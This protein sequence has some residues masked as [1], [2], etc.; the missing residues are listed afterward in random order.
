MKTILEYLKRRNKQVYNAV[1]LDGGNITL[2]TG[3]TT[4]VMRAIPMT[5]TWYD[6][7]SYKDLRAATLEEYRLI[8]DYHNEINQVLKDNHLPELPYDEYW[9]CETKAKDTGVTATLFKHDTFIMSRGQ[10]RNLEFPTIL[11][12]I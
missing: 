8:H 5:G 9:T 1:T 3:D 11:V 2:N 7:Q 6:A 12:E 10:D 4:I